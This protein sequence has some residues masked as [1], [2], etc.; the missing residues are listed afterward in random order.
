MKIMIDDELMTVT[1]WQNKAPVELPNPKAIHIGGGVHLVHSETA[2][3]MKEVS[4]VR[5]VP[6][7][8]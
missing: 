8:G 3:A 5:T 6:R 7:N 1:K 2:K 4:D